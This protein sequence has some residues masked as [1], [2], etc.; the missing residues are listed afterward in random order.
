MPRTFTHSHRKASETRFPGNPGGQQFALQFDLS[1]LERYSSFH[2]VLQAAVNTCGR[3]DNHIAADCGYS[4]QEFSRRMADLESDPG[5]P[6]PVKRLDKLFD[7]I[8]P[9]MPI[10]WLVMKYMQNPEVKKD[11]AIAT[12]ERA[13][14]VLANALA[15]LQER[16]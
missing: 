7:A 10:E 15:V 2:S 5:H 12:V 8:D 3:P 16:N 13:A 6:F 1:L 11:Q 4:P 9:S 14:R